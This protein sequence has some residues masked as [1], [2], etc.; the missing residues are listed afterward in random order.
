MQNWSGSNFP[1]R[2]GVRAV[3]PKSKLTSGSTRSM[4]RLLA[5]RSFALKY[6]PRNPCRASRL[7]AGEIRDQVGEV[8][9][10][11]VTGQV[12]K[13]DRGGCSRAGVN[14][15]E[16]VIDIRGDFWHASAGYDPGID[17]ASIDESVCQL[18]G[19]FDPPSAACCFLR[20]TTHRVR[21]AG[22]F[23]LC[24]WLAP[25]NRFG[26]PQNC[27]GAEYR[28]TAALEQNRDLRKGAKPRAG[29]SVARCSK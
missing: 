20:P 7:A 2:A 12:R 16:R 29:G 17:P 4:S 8:F 27:C 10:Y 21:G 13:I 25:V 1:L 22:T 5:R 26:G 9:R 28:K 23:L 15:I 14:G 3:R 19:R 24:K 18:R 6:S 11:C